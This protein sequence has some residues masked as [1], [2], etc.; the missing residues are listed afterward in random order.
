VRNCG[1]SLRNRPA[2]ASTSLPAC[3]P[4]V[5]LLCAGISQIHRAN[6]VA[7]AR[8]ATPGRHIGEPPTPKWSFRSKKDVNRHALP[9]YWQLPR[10][11][12]HESVRSFDE[13][14]G[15]RVRQIEMHEADHRNALVNV[16]LVHKPALFSAVAD[17]SARTDGPA[18]SARRAVKLCWQQPAYRRQAKACH[19]PMASQLLSRKAS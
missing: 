18:A 1:R 19:S 13:S 15:E 3:L 14:S 5:V 4:E 12:H 17:F 16:S 7:Y 6:P 11:W 9:A 8:Q 2:I 10:Y